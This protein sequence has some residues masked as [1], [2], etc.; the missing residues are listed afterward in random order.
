MKILLLLAYII[1]PSEIA[2]SESS[3]ARITKLI[4]S[5]VYQSDESVKLAV[6]YEIPNLCFESADANISEHLE[7][8]LLKVS[9]PLKR[10]TKTCA[11]IKR[12]ES[13]LV[14]LPPLREGYYRA[15]ANSGRVTTLFQTVDKM[16]GEVAELN[17]FTQ[18]MDYEQKL[19]LEISAS[20]NNSCEFL[21]E[22]KYFLNGRTLTVIPY[23]KTVFDSTCEAREVQTTET[24]AT[25][26][27]SDEVKNLAIKSTD[28]AYYF[29]YREPF[30][31]EWIFI[32]PDI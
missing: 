32:N 18:D 4:S 5:Y 28:G 19:N 25:P 23:K 8:G 27:R 11:Q 26:F 29:A 6:V 31:N 10:L 2:L 17:Y 12:I 24:F 15:I 16:K 22:P 3:E 14:T 1:L 21:S 7:D 30:N 20:L 13:Q 9:V